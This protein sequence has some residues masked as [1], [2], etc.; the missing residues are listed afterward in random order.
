MQ[1]VDDVQI[2]YNENKALVIKFKVQGMLNDSYI[3][4]SKFNLK[5]ANN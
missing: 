2:T 3:K 4:Q 5:H 1:T